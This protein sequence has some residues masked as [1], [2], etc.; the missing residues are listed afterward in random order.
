MRPGLLMELEAAGLAKQVHG[1][2]RNLDHQVEA[3]GQQLGQ[4]GV[5]V[6]QRAEDH[7]LELG[8]AV[9]VV[10]VALDHDLGVAL[11]LGEAVGARAGRLAAE[12][13]AA[14]ADGFGRYDQAGRIGEVRQQRG[15]GFLQVEDDRSRIGGFGSFDGAEEEG[16]REGAG[17]VLR[18]L[19]VQ[20][21]VEVEL[22]RLGIERRAV[23]ELDA[24]PEREGVGLAVRGNLPLLGQRR[25]DLQRAAA[26]P[27]EAVIE[28]HQDTEIVGR[29]DRVRVQR[30]RLRDLADDQ[31]I[32][33]DLR[34]CGR[35]AERREHQERAAR[36][37]PAVL[38]CHGP[39]LSADFPWFGND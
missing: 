18:V 35:R 25:F 23:V 6:G 19:V 8:C 13:L 21:A 5:G 3:A 27:D 37:F 20:H 7:G 38:P 33:G 29:R 22:D 39:G 32:V 31:D 10:G 2:G 28:V 24:L 1:V 17:V 11:P 26:E 36:R 16:E 12:I 30:L 14:L 9:P 4:A 34:R 15:V